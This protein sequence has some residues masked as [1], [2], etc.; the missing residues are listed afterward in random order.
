MQLYTD[1]PFIASNEPFLPAEPPGGNKKNG[2]FVITERNY[3]VIKVN[4][5]SWTNAFLGFT[6]YSWS[7]YIRHDIL[8]TFYPVFL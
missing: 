7:Y 8:G 6:L 3:I 4:P 5:K 2:S 1:G